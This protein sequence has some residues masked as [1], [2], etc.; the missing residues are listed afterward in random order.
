MIEL[1]DVNKNRALIFF[2]IVLVGSIYHLVRDL[3]QIGGIENFFT[4]VGH[5]NHNWCAEYCD[6]VT[7]P[8]DIFLI[9]GAIV[10]VR[11]KK[12]GILGLSVLVVLLLGLLMW[13]MK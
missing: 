10:I 7:L 2:K 4:Q 13:L 11:R 9:V 6:Y 1:S 8:I 12:I 5:W 3:L